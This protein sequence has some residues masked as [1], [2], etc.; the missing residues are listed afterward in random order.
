[1]IEYEYDMDGLPN[2]CSAH[3][4][5]GNDLTWIMVCRV[6]R[7]VS[8]YQL[9]G[10]IANELYHDVEIEPNLIPDSG[11]MLHHT[12][13]RQQDAR[14]DISIRDFWQRGQ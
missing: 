9:I 11:E 4:Y 14:L 13:N 12:A 10:H 2:T 3:V 7:V 1:M 6:K 5:V 8:I